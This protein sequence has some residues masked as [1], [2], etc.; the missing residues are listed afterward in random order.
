MNQ[1]ERIAKLMASV[2]MAIEETA[3]ETGG[4]LTTS[5][6][7]NVLLKTA[8]GYNGNQM[9]SEPQPQDPI[10]ESQINNMHVVDAETE[11]A[12]EE[13]HI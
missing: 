5:E 3:S 7:V 1:E 13:K 12:D 11:Q 2:G 8:Y 9:R 4:N 10:Y 6:V